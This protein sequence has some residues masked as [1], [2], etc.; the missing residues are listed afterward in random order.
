MINIKGGVGMIGF[1][2]Y[3]MS[4][5]KHAE[6]INLIYSAV[7]S[8]WESDTFHI[9][10]EM[11]F[12]REDKIR[13]VQVYRRKDGYRIEIVLYEIQNGKEQVTLYTVNGVPKEV[14]TMVFNEIIIAGYFAD[15]E[16]WKD[17]SGRLSTNKQ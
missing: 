2:F 9:L 15:F 11:F 4:D 7:D 10:V 12:P 5:L 8:L 3:N 1:S 17:E 13:S 14:V 6:I 16:E